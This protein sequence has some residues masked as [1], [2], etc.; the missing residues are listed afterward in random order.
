MRPHVLLVGG[1]DHHL[2]MPFF[3]AL[4]ALGHRVSIAATGGRKAFED[5]GF[6]FHSFAL[7]RF[8]D[9]PGDLRT[10][11]A[12]AALLREVDADV[13]HSFD[14]KISLLLPMAARANPR[15]AI[16]R[17]INGR[18]WVFSSSSPAAMALRAAYLVLQRAASAMT[19][20]TIFEH[21]GDQTFFARMRLMGK[22]AS[23]L[24][25][26]AGIDIEGFESAQRSGP[27]PAQ[28][29]RELGLDDA[30]IVATVTRVTREKGVIP[31]LQAADI[32]ARARP[33]VR[34]LVVGPRESEGPFAVPEAEFAKRRPHVIATGPRTDVPSLLA[35]VDVFAFPSEYAEGVPRAIME[36]ALSQLPIV[37]TDI[38]GCREV[39]TDGW[40]GLLTPKR[41]PAKLA[42]R[43]EELLANRER[44]TQLASH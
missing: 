4:R 43:I 34:F 23:V 41:N 22:S 38:A 5:A 26:G 3:Q 25:P 39:V 14:T 32:L 9:V 36:A 27:T 28:L 35:A 20:A 30:E 40:N 15:T 31:L 33:K 11:A 44:A 6:P 12:L 10:R 18:G 19:D 13:A 1:E 29:R 17:T 37:A 2:R 24:I 8:W 21:S 7:N 42:A 16:V